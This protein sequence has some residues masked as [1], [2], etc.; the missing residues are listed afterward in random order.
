MKLLSSRI[1]LK[2]ISSDKVLP[3]I[4]KI[5]PILV[6]VIIVIVFLF[7][8]EDITVENLLSY[9]PDEPIWAALFMLFMF[10]AKSLS[11]VFP[12]IILEITVGIIYPT[13]PALIINSLGILTSF[14]T[15]YYIGKLSGTELMDKLH[16]KLDKFEKLNKISERAKSG[17]WFGAFFLRIVSVLP[18][19][20][21]SM[22]LGANHMPLK[23]YL[24]GSYLGSL[25]GIVAATLMGTSVTDPRSPVFIASTVFTILISVGSLIIYLIYNKNKKESD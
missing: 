7:S 17:K 24:L 4:L 5:M 14:I 12:L 8:K 13:V 22:Y 3:E 20:P 19:D 10:A 25:P 21:V 15:G 9:V 1:K 16:K 6:C 18:M 23:P 2:K 11:T